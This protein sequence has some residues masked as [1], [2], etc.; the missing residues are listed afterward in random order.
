MNG[1]WHNMRVT[2]L[3]VAACSLLHSLWILFVLR[4]QMPAVG[5]VIDD[6]WWRRLLPWQTQMI[7]DISGLWWVIPILLVALLLAMLK[8]DLH[9]RS[10]T[11]LL[12]LLGLV[13][14]TGT[15]VGTHIILMEGLRQ[16]L[17][18]IEEGILSGI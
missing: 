18:H 7:F 9:A 11:R 8:W 14:L 5:D 6:L 12:L 2:T 17:L 1:K 16:V 13:F 3:T 4:Y 15:C 10:G